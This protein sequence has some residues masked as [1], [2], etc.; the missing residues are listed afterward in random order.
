MR[1]INERTRV[2]RCEKDDKGSAGTNHRRQVAGSAAPASNAVVVAL[3]F[4]PMPVHR[5]RLGKFV[6][7]CYFHWLRSCEYD[8]WS[9]NATRYFCQWSCPFL[10][11]KRHARI[12]TVASGQWLRNE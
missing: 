9:G 10:K 11:R 2:G 12:V 6:Q 4:H 3:Q 8:W 5:S 1:V 7:N